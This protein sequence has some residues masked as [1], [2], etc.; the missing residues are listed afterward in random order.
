MTKGRVK[1]EAMKILKNRTD[2]SGDTE[3]VRKWRKR[4]RVSNSW[5]RKFRQ[6]HRD[7]SRRRGDAITRK[8]AAV[9]PG[10]AQRYFELLSGAGPLE[11]DRVYNMD[12][13]HIDPTAGDK[14]VF[15]SR[16]AK[17]AYRA[18]SGSTEGCTLVLCGNAVGDV[19][20]PFFISKGTDGRPAKWHHSVLP[21]ISVEGGLSDIRVA[22][23]VSLRA[24]LQLNCAATVLESLTVPLTSPVATVSGLFFAVFR[25]DGCRHVLAMAEEDFFAGD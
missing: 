15:V 6:R 5:F 19:V 11:R 16:G 8:K 21:E 25:L 12:E 3:H 23:Q 10:H 9:D 2:R 18:Q 17:K 13:T 24:Y 22:Q 1:S 4:N 20:P 7:L 14:Y